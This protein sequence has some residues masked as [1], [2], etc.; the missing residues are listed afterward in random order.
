MEKIDEFLVAERTY[1]DDESKL[2]VGLANI[3]AEVPD[4][5]ANRDKVL[6]AVKIFKERKVNVAVFPEFCLSGYFWDAREDCLEYLEEAVTEAN[7]EWIESELVP[8][9]GDGLEMILMNNL[10]ATEDE[11]RFLNRTFAVDG[12]DDY[13]TEDPPTTR[14]SSRA[15]RRTTPTAAATTGWS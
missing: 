4:V 7:Q 12:G 9:L 10:T 8:L 15:S 13:L 6:R 2:S 3:H 11:G 5:E 14:S 1:C